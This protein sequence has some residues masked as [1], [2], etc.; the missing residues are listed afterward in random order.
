LVRDNYQKISSTVKLV[1]PSD[2]NLKFEFE[3]IPSSCPTYDAKK[4]SEC[5][6]VKIGQKV[7]IQVKVTARSCPEPNSNPATSVDVG[8]PGFGDV[9]V[10]IKYLCDC[11]CSSNTQNNSPLCTNRGTLECG[12]CKCNKGFFGSVCQCDASTQGSVNDTLTCIDSTGDNSTLCSGKGSCVC[13]KC[14]CFKETG[15]RLVSGP[16]CQ[17]KNFGCNQFEGKECGGASRGSCVCNKCECKEEFTGSG[18]GSR[19]C[20]VTKEK[21]CTIDGVECNNNG[22][23]DCPTAKCKCNIGFTGSHCQTCVRK[24]CK[25]EQHQNCVLCGVFDGRL[26]IND[27]TKKV[28]TELSKERKE[29]LNCSL[30]KDLKVVMQNATKRTCSTIFNVSCKAI[31]HYETDQKS[32][33]D[34]LFIQRY[35]ECAAPLTDDNPDSLAIVLGTIAGIVLLGILLLLIFKLLVTLH[36]KRE[37][38]RFEKSNKK[39]QW[40]EDAN[41]IYHPPEQQFENPAF[42]GEQ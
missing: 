32:G 13:G 4:P 15:N 42:A 20:P 2:E 40:Q 6:N 37:Y 10:A 3:V 38:K 26:E 5:S 36:D 19:N 33:N 24:D 23:C 8:I 29:E 31:Y 25:C 39:S 17:C 16:F 21:Y 1:A 28:K 41:P 9:K 11:T 35:L 27:K 7:D 30:C 22:Q 14:E 34:T 18:C 12:I